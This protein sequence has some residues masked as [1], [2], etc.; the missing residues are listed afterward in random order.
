MELLIRMNTLTNSSIF[1][2]IIQFHIEKKKYNVVEI[3]T[4]LYEFDQILLGS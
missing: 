3:N 4:V 2:L 1:D